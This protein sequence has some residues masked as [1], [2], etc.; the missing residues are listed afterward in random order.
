LNK[1]NSQ[2][3][4]QGCPK[5]ALE[6]FNQSISSSENK[7]LI[8]NIYRD[9]F[10]RPYLLS[11]EICEKY[12]IK[13]QDLKNMYSFLRSSES[14]RNLFNFS[15]YYY[16]GA[17]LTRLTRDYK[18]TYSILKG[19]T[20]SCLFETMELFISE[21]C[22]ALCKF[23]YR[24]G[25]LYQ[26]TK[27]MSSLDYINLIN[28]FADNQ[29]KNIDVSGGLEPLLSPE[30]I[31]IIQTGLKRGLKVRLYTNGIALTD[32]D[33]INNIMR[34]HTIRVSLNAHNQVSYKE[35]M[36]VNK[37]E[38]VISNLINLVKI[39]EET[40]SSVEIGISFIILGQ[41][42]VHIRDIIKIAQKLNVDFLDLRVQEATED[43]VFTEKQRKELET[44]LTKVRQKNAANG[45]GKLRISVADA[46]NPLQDPSNKYLNYIRED[47]INVLSY[48]RITVTPQGKIYALNI[49]GQPS[50]ED[51]R[52]LLGELSEKN[53]LS[54]LLANKKSI[55]FQKKFLLAHDIT[56]LIALSKLANDLEFGIDLQDNPFNWQGKVEESKLSDGEM[57]PDTIR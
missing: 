36:G 51:P 17:L 13:K 29:G 4:I 43:P 9:L 22:N 21:N 34:I 23:C 31:Y 16:V 33:I 45:F 46:S 28:E 15:P 26:K 42:Y 8:F 6:D 24:N 7:D 53:S 32:S 3:D 54:E 49:I 10:F 41:N 14:A 55:P 12:C 39:K 18:R 25:G 40:G 2:L 19:Q 50:R 52:Y 44:I 11:K 48:F 38:C 30:L 37:F 47:L 35:I 5:K 1:V 27:L 20:P 56:L 57:Y